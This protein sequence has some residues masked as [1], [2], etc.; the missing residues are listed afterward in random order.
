MG[1]PVFKYHSSYE[2]L[3]VF[4]VKIERADKTN[5]S[6]KFSKGLDLTESSGS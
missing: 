1:F 4:K 3:F 6:S 2:M 5:C